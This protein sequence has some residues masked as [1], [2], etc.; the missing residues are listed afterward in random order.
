MSRS[1]FRSLLLVVALLLS[2]CSATAPESGDAGARDAS[3]T[4]SLPAAGAARP[5]PTTVPPTA[6]ATSAPTVTR[7]PSSEAAASAATATSPA[8]EVTSEA[9]APPVT[10]IM[11]QLGLAGEPYAADG[12]PN[13]PLTVVEFSDFG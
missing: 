1:V 5:T 13:A 8:G 7:T 9:P 2:A 12:D 4:S 11:A 3:A 6:T 10:A